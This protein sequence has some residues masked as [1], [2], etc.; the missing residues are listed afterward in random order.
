M[1]RRTINTVIKMTIDE[2]FF[3]G[4]LDDF[5]PRVND[6][7]KSPKYALNDTDLRALAEKLNIYFDKLSVIYPNK[8]KPINPLLTPQETSN[9]NTVG[10]L[11][12]LIQ[13]RVSLFIA[14]FSLLFLIS[15]GGE[16]EAGLYLEDYDLD[17]D[18]GSVSVEERRV[19]V[20][21]QKFPFLTK[22]DRN[23][24]G[25]IDPSELSALNAFIQNQADNRLDDMFSPNN[26]EEEDAIA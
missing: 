13:P 3:N 24:N 14:F 17:N 8:V 21:H 9:K 23:K 1:K 4:D 11:R 22:V 19:F 12:Q 2:V 15:F 6:N 26:I 10:K 7:L 16:A 25:R 5:E 20:T 18:P